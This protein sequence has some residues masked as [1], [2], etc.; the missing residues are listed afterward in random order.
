MQHLQWTR[1]K[2]SLGNLERGKPMGNPFLYI[3]V[4][5]L[6]SEGSYCKRTRT[7]A[8]TLISQYVMILVA[9][10]YLPP[11]EASVICITVVL[12][13]QVHCILICEKYLG[14]LLYS[15]TTAMQI[16]FW[17]YIYKS[18]IW[19]DFT[20]FGNNFSDYSHILLREGNVLGL[21]FVS[22]LCS[23]SGRVEDRDKLITCFVAF[24]YILE[25]GN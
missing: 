5:L 14:K 7:V 9:S 3:M 17:T 10:S 15:V 16:L 8:R 19:I 2:Q 24:L 21:T 25:Y 20:L 18:S 4:L 12:I 11:V 23:K 13:T 6:Y 22:Y 1:L